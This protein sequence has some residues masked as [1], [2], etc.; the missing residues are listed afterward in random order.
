MM[1]HHRTQ[2]LAVG[3]A[4]ASR[5]RLQNLL[6]YDTHER[7]VRVE[8]TQSGLRAVIA[9]HSTV[10]GPAGG[11]CRLWT[12]QSQG[13]AISDVLNLSRGMTYKN[14]LA[15][16]GFGPAFWMFCA[17]V[18]LVVVQDNFL[19]RWSVWNSLEKPKT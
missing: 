7:V 1:Q 10:L 4:G 16:V 19:C 17:L 12:Y 8:D 15:D 2:E 5:L 14:A 13:D 9:I 18:F 6:G 11:G 3:N